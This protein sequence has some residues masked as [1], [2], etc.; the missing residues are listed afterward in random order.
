MSKSA[1]SH[2]APRVL[3][4]RSARP[5]VSAVEESPTRDSA[6]TLEDILAVAAREFESKGFDGARVDA[7]AEAT[8]TSKRMIYYHFDGKEG[9][10]IA[11]L[12]VAYRRIREIE[13]SLSLDHLD[14]IEALKKLTGF[15]YDYHVTNPGFVRLVMTENINQ[16][17]YLARSKVIQSLNNSA[18]ETVGA[19]YQRGV[20][21]G[22]FR[23]GIKALDLH[24]L[25]SALSFHNVSNRSTFALI[26][27]QDV[28]TAEALAAR[29][30]FIVES[31]VR[32][33]LK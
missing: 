16:G 1:S 19:I 9:L 24:F 21:T 6:K 4:K 28:E 29:R 33:V 3:P 11:V 22:V 26:F 25:I 5:A 17:V 12:E 2:P 30:D 10:Y 7:I 14:P 18:L 32:S 15:T 13:A 20:R 27:K 8:R 31:V 23:A